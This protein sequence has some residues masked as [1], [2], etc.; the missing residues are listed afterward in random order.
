MVQA[1]VRPLRAGRDAGAGTTRVQPE[2]AACTLRHAGR[3]AGTGAA[4]K[5]SAPRTP[6]AAA[7][8][9]APRAPPARVAGRGTGAGAATERATHAAGLL[10][11]VPLDPLVD[12]GALQPSRHAALSGCLWDRQLIHNSGVCGCLEDTFALRLAA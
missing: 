8:A 1:V 3:G 6:L 7:A 5:R 4:M 11:E 12:C 2:V 10:V 9:A